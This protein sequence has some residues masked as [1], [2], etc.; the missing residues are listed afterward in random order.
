MEPNL[1]GKVVELREQILW[2]GIVRAVC[3]KSKTGSQTSVQKDAGF[4]QGR[5]TEKSVGS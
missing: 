3:E 2:G 1:V 4:Y 5:L